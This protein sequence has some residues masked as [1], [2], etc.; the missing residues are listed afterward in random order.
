V[1]RGQPVAI[2][3][4]RAR[5]AGVRRRQKVSRGIRKGTVKIENHTAHDAKILYLGL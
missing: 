3:E 2:A 1:K 5:Q 4:D